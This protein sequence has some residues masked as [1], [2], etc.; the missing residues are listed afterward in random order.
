M[1]LRV[2]SRFAIAVLAF[3]LISQIS[4]AA[5]RN[6]FIAELSEFEIVVEGLSTCME[7]LGIT[8]SYIEDRVELACRRSSLPVKSDA[9]P[10][11]YIDIVSL[12]TTIRGQCTGYVY[13][14]YVS[15]NE[16]IKNPTSGKYQMVELWHAPG[17]LHVCGPNKETLRQALQYDLQEAVEAFE[18]V[19]L[20]SH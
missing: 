5:E 9:G 12:P 15:M 13:H 10:F 2:S 16:A 4:H 14:L 8:E 19:W 18:N 3:T 20:A 1:K 7:D 6:E 11:L 17:S